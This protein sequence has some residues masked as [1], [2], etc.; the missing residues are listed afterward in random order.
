MFEFIKPDFKVLENDKVPHARQFIVQP[1]AQGFGTTLGNSLRRVLLSVLPGT[2]VFAF[3]LS[4]A[5]QEFQTLPGIHENVLQIGLNIEKIILR[6]N[7]VLFESSPYLKLVL[8]VQPGAKTIFARDIEP[9]SGVTIV[10]PDLVLAT[11]VETKQPLEMT[12]LIRKGAGYATFQ[13][14]QRFL[15]KQAETAIGFIAVN[16]QF[17]PIKRVHFQTQEIRVGEETVLEKLTLGIE[18]NGA[19]TAKDCFGQACQILLVHLNHL[20]ESNAGYDDFKLEDQIVEP[21]S[22]DDAVLLQEL[23]FSERTINALHNNG[24]KTLKQLQALSKKEILEI[25][26]LGQKSLKEIEEKL[27]TEYNIKI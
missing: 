19:L 26:N 4:N 11:I 20:T 16:S 1:L 17:S 10:N 25:K 5:E 14:N 6:V 7:F 2:A 22:K 3:R 23:D 27:K 9:V 12:F 13:E 8:K 18:T 21:V 15:A 24:I